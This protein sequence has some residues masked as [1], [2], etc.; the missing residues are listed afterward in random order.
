MTA[1][2][3]CG[4]DDSGLGKRYAVTGTVKYKGAPVE[5]GSITF[6]PAGGTAEGRHATGTIENGSYKLTTTGEGG[7]GALPGNYKV[8]VIATSVDMRDLAKKSGGLVHQG[9]ADFAK[10]V[11]E[12]KDLVPKKYSKSETSGL[13][14]KV[15]AKSQEINFNLED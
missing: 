5:H 14:A 6:E 13:T 12:A 2:G 9:D 10:I 15:E 1:V 3:G 4:A 11:K 7:D 8:I